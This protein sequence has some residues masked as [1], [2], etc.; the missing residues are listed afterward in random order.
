MD[1]IKYFFFFLLLNSLP[2]K[3]QLDPASIR[4]NLPDTILSIENTL[5]LV[6]ENTA[7][8]FSY[9]PDLFDRD[10]AVE[11]KSGNYSLQ[12]IIERI[13]DL[14]GVLFTVIDNQI[15]FHKKEQEPTLPEYSRDLPLH[16]VR[17]IVRGRVLSSSGHESIAYATVWLSSTWQGTITNSK[18]FFI[19]NLPPSESEDTLSI[20]C[21]GYKSRSI[22]LSE[23]SDSMN[24]IHLQTSIIPIQEVV[25]RRTDP[26]HL[27]R[28]AIKRIP[29]N[30]S[31]DPVIETAFYRETIQKDDVYISVSEAVIDVYKPGVESLSAEQVKV[32]RARKNI[33]FKKTDTVMIKLKAGL[34]T[35][36]LLDLIRNRPDFLLEDQFSRYEYRMSD[37]VV[38]QDKNTYAIDFNQK[39]NTTAPHFQGRIYIDLESLAFRGVEFEV[40]PQ[41]ISSITNSTVIKKPRK[42]K[43]RPLSASYYVRYKSEEG[44]FYLSL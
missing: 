16:P 44:K 19:L 12:G 10:L 32:L 18:G 33:D 14:Q 41:T 29:E 9:N 27:L 21:M 35:S 5:F 25:I 31:S 26:I 11:W 3:A 7:V 1:V 2:G 24:T 6:E 28:E 34:E 13:G 38:M 40:N 30:N 20:S 42:L 22:S 8:Y 36:F 23:L 15:V 39:V 4:V 17:Q 37:I 43:V